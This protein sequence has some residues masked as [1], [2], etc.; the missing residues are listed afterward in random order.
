METRVPNIDI[1]RKA[2]LKR[3]VSSSKQFVVYADGLPIRG[4]FCVFS[5]GVK[6]ELLGLLGAGADDSAWTSPVVIRVETGD[7]NGTVPRGRSISTVIR[8]YDFG[9]WLLQLDVFLGADFSREELEE[10]IVRLLLAERILADA[11]M[12]VVTKRQTRILPDWLHYGIVGVI[13]Y[14][15]TGRP[16]DTFQAIWKA[17]VPLNIDEVL[18]GDYRS[19]DALSKK[20]FEASSTG[21]VYALHRQRQGRL[22]MRT[23]VGNLGRLDIDQREIVGRHYPNLAKSRDSIDKWWTLEMAALAEGSAFEMLDAQQT[24]TRLKET[25]DIHYREA[26]DVKSTLFRPH[27][28]ALKK[29]VL[30]SGPRER[31]TITLRQLE[32]IKKHPERELILVRKTEELLSLSLRAFPLYQPVIQGYVDLIAKASQGKGERDLEQRLLDLESRRNEI[33]LI[34]SRA[35]HLL[36]FYEATETTHLSSDFEDYL[37]V[38]ESFQQPAPPRPDPISRYLDRMEREWQ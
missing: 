17:G 31:I 34:V 23:M 25:L 18:D 20:M 14:R 6:S 19:M 10:E 2:E 7:G 27:S 35:D 9:G 38:M 8:P 5:E 11:R 26:E 13:R 12:D 3:S 30:P 29:P 24:E 32:Q 4:E 28:E 15:R 33:L 22:A 21:L 36:D 37:Q 1:K 16:S